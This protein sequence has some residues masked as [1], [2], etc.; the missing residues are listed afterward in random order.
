M[1]LAL[2]DYDA[3]RGS[4]PY[5]LTMKAKSRMVKVAKGERLTGQPSRRHGQESAKEPYT[6]SLDA[7]RLEDGS[8]LAEV[9]PDPTDI[10]D[11]A[12]LV[13]HHAEVTAAIRKLSPLQQRYLATRF[14][15]QLTNA[16][17]RAAQPYSYDANWNRPVTGSRARLAE[18]LAH[19]RDADG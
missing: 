5:W 11:R 16:E 2:E 12:E 3:S 6:L 1:W 13:A 18:E 9:V 17:Q 15:L 4:L 10:I 14:W 7:P 8:T 19:L